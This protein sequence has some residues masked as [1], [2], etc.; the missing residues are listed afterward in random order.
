MRRYPEGIWGDGDPRNERRDLARSNGGNRHRR[1]RRTKV[2]AVAAAKWSRTYVNKHTPKQ[3]P[4][5]KNN[6]VEAV[7]AAKGSRTCVINARYTPTCIYILVY[8]L[9][10]SV[11]SKGGS[12]HGGRRNKTK[13]QSRGG[14]G[15][16]VGTYVLTSVRNIY[17]PTCVYIYRYVLFIFLC[18]RSKGGSRHRRRQRNRGGSGCKSGHVRTYVNIYQVYIIYI[19]ITNITCER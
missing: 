9:L 16:K 6:D 15:C 5:A 2:E 13:K 7:A 1:R 8:S 4:S 17:T 14:G 18:A 11:R 12:R 19:C 3:A 10:F